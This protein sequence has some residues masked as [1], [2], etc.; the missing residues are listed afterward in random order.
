[1]F[2]WVAALTA[3]LLLSHGF[4][5]F[6]SAAT[7][8]GCSSCSPLAGAVAWR[9][10]PTLQALNIA[11]VLLTLALA[12]FRLRDGRIRVG[13]VSEYAWALVVSVSSAV[14]GAAIL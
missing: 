10:S 2:L 9:A 4:T 12:A 6:P 14:I 11:A 3:A 7:G 13:H 5:A 1:V 8:A